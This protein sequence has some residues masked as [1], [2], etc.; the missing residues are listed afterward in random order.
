MKKSLLLIAFAII[1]KFSSAQITFEHSYDSASLFNEVGSLYMINLE[2]S[3]EKYVR[4]SNSSD[5]SRKTITIYNMDHSVWKSIDCRPMWISAFSSIPNINYTNFSTVSIMYISE[6]L[7]N[8][9]DSLEF[10]ITFGTSTIAYTGV[11]NEAGTPLFITTSGSPIV[12]GNIP[13][14]MVPIYN[15]SQGTK[16]II[17][18]FDGTAKV[19]SLGGSL[20]TIVHMLPQDNNGDFRLS[21]NP[22][23]VATKV[24][25]NLPEGEQNGVIKV[26]DL[27][28]RDIRE[29]RVDNT[30]HDLVISNTD[31][32]SG[33]YIFSMFCNN[34]IASKKQVIV[35]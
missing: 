20:T 4:I 14:A 31:L 1:V 19:Y 11:F 35:H 25:F 27:N 29:Y 17:S 30:F 34:H 2:A 16:M 10:M 18:F 12:N 26:S 32:P 7:F 15:T 33:T 21:P 23:S 28:G 13:H 3:G 22:S 6:H 9:D 24:D 5:D 8:T